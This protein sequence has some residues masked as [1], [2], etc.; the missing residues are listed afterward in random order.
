MSS[1]E[2]SNLRNKE[3][4]YAVAMARVQV[5]C[6]ALSPLLSCPAR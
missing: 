6:A 4:L 2:L 3:E 1:D 5:K